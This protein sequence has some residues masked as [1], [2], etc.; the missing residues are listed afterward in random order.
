MNPMPE[1][2]PIEYFENIRQTMTTVRN[3]T[4]GMDGAFM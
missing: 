4:D 1:G 2:P 3:N